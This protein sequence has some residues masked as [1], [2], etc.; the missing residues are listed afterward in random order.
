MRYLFIL[1]TGLF[2]SLAVTGQ[3]VDKSKPDIDAIK[4]KMVLRPNT[5]DVNSTVHDNMKRMQMHKRRQQHKSV[6]QK[7]MMERHMGKRQ[8]QRLQRQRMIQQK[9][10]RQHAIQRRQ[11]QGR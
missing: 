5:R 1:L 11:M 8:H 7:Q 4:S 10:I 3:E 2:F 9:R 6:Q